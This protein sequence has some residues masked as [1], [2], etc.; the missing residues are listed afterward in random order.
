M[1]TKSVAAAALVALLLFTLP[2]APAL[3]AHSA[4]YRPGQRPIAL[5]LLAGATGGAVIG[6]DGDHL[7]LG[8]VTLPDGTNVPTKWTGGPANWT[9][10]DL[11]AGGQ[12]TGRANSI[13]RHGD[14]L[15]NDRENSRAWVVTTDGTAHELHGFG[16][17]SSG[18][19]AGMNRRGQIAGAVFGPAPAY[20]AYGAVWANYAAT[21]RHLD[22][23]PFP[24]SADSFALGINNEGVAVGNS[25]N[26]DFSDH[27]G[28]AWLP[29]SSRGFVLP[30]LS[31]SYHSFPISINDCNV[32]VGDA[33]SADL[34]IDGA[35]AWVGRRLDFLGTAI[36]TDDSADLFGLANSGRAVGVSYRS[37]GPSNRAIYW[38]GLPSH[39][40]RILSPLSG[41]WRTGQA[42]AHYVSDDGLV[43]GDSTDASGNDVPVVWLDAD[44]ESFLPASSTG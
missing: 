30:G 42:S 44:A 38:S 1:R 6:G 29:G 25:G 41:T 21:P 2:A 14:I 39:T 37:S 20:V 43:G 11:S 34:S 23:L 12:L 28:G 3:A 36:P 13:D 5:P 9:V 16:G 19:F 24:G 18:V 27:A 15:I 26:A 33:S 35:A 17:P 31:G 32:A 7:L 4:A 22:P 8:S 40:L 10:T